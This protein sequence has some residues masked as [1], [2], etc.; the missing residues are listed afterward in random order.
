L[1]ISCF[2]L[3]LFKVRDLLEILE[4]SLEKLEILLLL[5]LE[6]NRDFIIIIRQTKNLYINKPGAL[7]NY[8]IL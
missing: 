7:L 6:W 5:L 1:I 2:P 3:N 8:F 4:I